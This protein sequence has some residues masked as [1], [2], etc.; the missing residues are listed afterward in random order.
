[1]FVHGNHHFITSRVGDAETKGK[2]FAYRFC[3][4]YPERNHHKIKNNVKHLKGACHGDDLSYVFS[5]HEYGPLPVEYTDEWVAIQKV[6]DMYVDFATKGSS[7][8]DEYGWEC[9]NKN[10]LPYEYKCMEISED[11][12]MTK[13]PELSRMQTWDSMFK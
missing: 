10:D 4:D 9:I 2:T 6:R 3:Y 12:K 11:W 8:L 7:A 5:M 1:M 13:A